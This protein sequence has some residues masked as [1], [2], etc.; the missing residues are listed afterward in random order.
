[1]EDY[2]KFIS[3]L[4]LPYL[5]TPPEVIPLI[6]NTLT[7]RFNLLCNSSQKLIDLGSGNGRIIVYSAINYGIKSV[8]IEI[9][10]N[11][12]EEAI[13]TIKSLKREKKISK[14]LIKLIEIRN[15]DLFTQDLRNYD[16]IYI[17]SLPSMQKSL[18]HLFKT[19]KS[20]SII[21]SFK[22]KLKSF[23]SYL[24]LEYCLENEVKNT[25]LKAFFYKKS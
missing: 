6:F 15:E 17:Y 23:K 5:G 25:I 13:E 1:M 16:F 9:D 22:Y 4:S 24:H 21:I 2:Q 11:L 14:K 18:N 7:E 19:A 8:G 20:Q 3:Q 10:K 12:I